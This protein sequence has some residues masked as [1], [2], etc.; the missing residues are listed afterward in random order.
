MK[1]LNEK[2]KKTLIKNLKICFVLLVLAIV[3]FFFP[4]FEKEEVQEN[5]E[6]SA[7]DKICELATLRCYYHNVAED[8]KQPDGLYKY[9]WFKYGYKKFWIEYDGIVEVGIDVGEVEV[10]PPDEQGTIEISIP[11]AKILNLYPN[12]DSM[13]EAIY[14]KG[15]FTD[16]TTEEKSIAF[17][18][19]EATMRENAESDESILTQAKEN[20]K[21]LLEQYVVNMGKQIGQE[22]QVKWIEVTKGEN[23]E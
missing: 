19:A 16:I 20:A 5:V 21:K 18:K 13:S 23:N 22:Y 6:F 2:E 10:S 3:I 11:D 15:V 1:L 17:A 14:E 4:N 12:E 8:E 9:G 7:I